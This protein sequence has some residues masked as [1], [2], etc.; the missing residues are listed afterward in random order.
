MEKEKRKKKILRITGICFIIAGFVGL[1]YFAHK[2]K[3]RADVLQGENNNLQKTVKGLQK[4][5]AIQAHALGKN[6]KNK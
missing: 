5:V 2:Q 6:S 3:E 1:G 4:T